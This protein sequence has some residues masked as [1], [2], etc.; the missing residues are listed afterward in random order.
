MIRKAKQK[1]IEKIH[2]YLTN[3]SD[4][5]VNWQSLSYLHRGLEVKLSTI[6]NAGRGVFTN[7]T[8]EEYDVI[9]EYSGQVI[10][11]STFKN[12]FFYR[13]QLGSHYSIM[14]NKDPISNPGSLINHRDPPNCYFYISNLLM[15]INE[16]KGRKT[17]LRLF[18]VALTT[19]LPGQELFL[20]YGKAYWDA[21]FQREKK[22]RQS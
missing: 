14:G 12:D 22:L 15:G 19:I 6:P 17:S 7:K 18:I 11:A 4:D 10:F 13:A 5:E 1:A 21:F 3:V 2:T 16:N 20:S 9:C 8:F